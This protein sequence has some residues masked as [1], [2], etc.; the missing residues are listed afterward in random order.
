[1][2]VENVSAADG[3]W[4]TNDLVKLGAKAV[5]KAGDSAVAKMALNEARPK[6]LPRFHSEP[7]DSE[8][9]SLEEQPGGL[10]EKALAAGKG[11]TYHSCAS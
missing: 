3:R 7:H 9:R 5:Y 1:L 10:G 2:L 4:L 6:A 8:P 11:N